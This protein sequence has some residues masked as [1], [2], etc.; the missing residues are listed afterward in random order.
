MTVG[1]IISEPIET[2]HLAEGAAKQER[3]ADLLRLDLREDLSKGC[4]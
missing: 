4:E 2:H 1:S 3:I